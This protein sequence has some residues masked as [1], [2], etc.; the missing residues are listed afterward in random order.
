M[1]IIKF[2]KKFKKI[3][4]TLFTTPSHSQGAGA[5]PEVASM[6]GRKFFSCDYSEAEG[7]DNLSRPVGIIK[8]AQDNAAKIY[9][10]KS[11]F[12]LTNGSTSGIVAA[13]NAILNRNDKVLICRNCHKSVYNG[14]V[15]TGAVPIWFMPYYNRDWG[16]YDP[17]NIDYLEEMLRKNK[18]IKLFI[19]TNP[20]YEGVI[21]DVNRIANICK[22]YNVKLLVDEA[23]GALWNFHRALGVPAILDGADIVVQ[24][25]H[26]TAGALNPSAILLIG[27]DS[28]ISPRQ[29]QESLNLITTTSPSYPLLINIEG[30]INYLNSEKGRAKISELVKNINRCVR[31][32][33]DI[34]NLEV[35][36]YNNDVTKILVKLTNV[37]GFELSN[38]L[39]E[40]YNIEDEL[41]NEKSV[42]FLTGI[43]TTKSKLKKLEKALTEICS[44]NIKITESGEDTNMLYTVEPRV[45]YTPALVWN[46]PYREVELKYSISRVAM[47]V[48]TNYPPGVPVLLPGE[49]IK[50]EHLDFLKDRKK[51]KVLA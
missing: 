36:T 30:T 4:R 12:F 2:V 44:D 18:D 48:I 16:I 32:L 5:A 38:I 14:L 47:E 35:Y 28:D 45:K 41:A 26:K 9:N 3:N 6:L 21:S 7:F 37:S 8:L 17:I 24:S 1:S 10:A 51:I 25:L 29:I 46:K 20:T 22:K 19:M 13:M 31:T 23:H 42:L 11:A 34:P 27:N 15:I 50:K 49:V 39:F 43:G 33:R 40:K